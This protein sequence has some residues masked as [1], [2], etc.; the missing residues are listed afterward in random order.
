MKQLKLFA[1]AVIAVFTV[2]CSTGAKMQ[3]MAYMGMAGDNQK[4]DEDLNKSVDVKESTGGKDTNPAWT[5]QIS[6]TEFTG[7]VRLSLSSRGLYSENGRYKLSIEMIE[8]DQ[9]MFG[10]DMT[11]TTHTRYTLTDSKTNSVLFD[12]VIIAPYTAK[13]G[14]AFLGNERLRIANEGSGKENIKQLIN[15]LMQLDIDQSN[16]AVVE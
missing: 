13:M 2:G 3:N 9:P 15:K 8:I 7:A 4:F 16:I 5:P 10:F 12:E 14:E 1:L 6:N 11:V